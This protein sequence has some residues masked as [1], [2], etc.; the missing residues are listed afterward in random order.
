[1]IW[2]SKYFIDRPVNWRV[3]VYRP[4]LQF[5]TEMSLSL[6]NR[7]WRNDYYFKEA[8]GAKPSCFQ[9]IRARIVKV[10]V[11]FYHVVFQRNKRNFQYI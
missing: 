11:P 5:A 6:G 7:V 9:K 3:Y 4:V 1:M 10:A 8:R 2:G